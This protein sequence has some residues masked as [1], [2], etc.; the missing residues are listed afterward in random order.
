MKCCATTK[1]GTPCKNTANH[2]KFCGIHVKKTNKGVPCRRKCMTEEEKRSASCKKVGGQKKR[3]GHNRERNF[4]VL[5][6]NETDETP[7]SYKAAADKTITEERF[8][9]KLRETLGDFPSG[10]CSLKGGNNLQFTLGV[11]PEFDTDDKLSAISQRS[12]WEKYLGKSHSETP[13]HL[14]VYRETDRWIF[15]R[16]SDVIDFIVNHCSWRILDTGRMKG[17]FVDQS[18]KGSRQYLTYEYR[19]TH[20]SHFLGANGDKGYEFI[21]LLKNNLTFHEEVDK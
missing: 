12:V 19:Q 1:A 2:G 10:S 20:K 9:S 15:F 18:K 14:L 5:F 21:K 17:D 4:G 13:A 16:M 6:C 11:I 8:L 7:V 3:D